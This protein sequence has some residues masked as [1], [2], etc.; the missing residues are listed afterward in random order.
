MAE[1][2]AK[3]DN[4]AFSRPVYKML[5]HSARVWDGARET[6]DKKKREKGIVKRYLER[7]DSLA[8]KAVFILSVLKEPIK[9]LAVLL[10]VV[11]C[12]A[13]IVHASSHDVVLGVYADGELVG[14]LNS[15]SPMSLAQNAIEADLTALLDTEYDLNM[16]IDYSF[17]NVKSPKILR[18]ADCYR[19][20][21][22][23]ASDDLA[24]AYALYIDDKYI[25]STLNFDEL[26]QLLKSV[27]GTNDEKK[28]IKNNISIVNQPALKTSVKSV[29]EIAELLNVEVELESEEVNT[30]RV[31]AELLD[32]GYST[33]DTGIPRFTSGSSKFTVPKTL[34]DGTKITTD[35]DELLHELDLVYTREEVITESLPFDISYVESDDYYTG[36]QLL[37]T[38]GREG[39]VEI[40]YE[41]EYDANGVISKTETGRRVISEPITEV[42]VLGTSA[43][44]TKNPSGSFIWPTNVPVGISSDYGG[45]ILFGSY[46]YHRGLDIPNWYGYDIW[47]ADSGVVSYAGFNSSY[48]YYIVIDHGEGINTVY[49]HC[50]R[51]YVRAGDE[52]VQGDV[53]AAIGATGVATADHLHFEITIDGATVNPADYLPELE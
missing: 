2:G 35:K 7:C 5:T 16:K 25:A 46:D 49:A 17:V 4:K 11:L 10:V 36:T 51:L 39:K 41:I 48:G 43:A 34:S 14:Y 12:G 1:K 37:K 19:I 44:P 6:V 27:Q 52:V 29:S 33:L 26:N 22:D 28:S 13:F 21:Y 9:N 53:I 50:S 31:T 24:D 38:V 8:K 32:G 20:L 42:I 30:L 15:K 3:K 40:T 45:R 23:I 18:D 47:A